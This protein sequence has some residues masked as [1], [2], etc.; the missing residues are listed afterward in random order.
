MVTYSPALSLSLSLSL[1]IG[2]TWTPWSSP[3]LSLSFGTTLDASLSLFPPLSIG[4]TLYA[5][6]HGHLQLYSLSLS[7]DDVG[8]LGVR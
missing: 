5:L 6:E 7:R 3:A 1:S 4:M 2:M 8:R